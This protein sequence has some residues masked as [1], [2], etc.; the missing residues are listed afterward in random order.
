MKLLDCAAVGELLGLN[1]AHV[2]DRLSK[3]ADFPAAYRVGER[4]LR[5]NE[6]EIRAWLLEQREVRHRE[7]SD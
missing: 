2:R 5:W 1:E 3:R 7:T 6:A 4:S